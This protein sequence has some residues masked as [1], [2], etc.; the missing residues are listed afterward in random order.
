MCYWITIFFLRKRGTLTFSPRI[1]STWPWHEK[2][3]MKIWSDYSRIQPPSYCLTNL[4]M[5]RKQHE[6]HAIF[7]FV[8]KYWQILKN[9]VWQICKCHANNTR[10]IKFLYLLTNIDKY[11]LTNLFY[12]ASNTRNMQFS[13]LL[14]NIDKYCLTNLFYHA[15]NTRNMQFLA[16]L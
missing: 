16:P 4:L 10:N 3:W 14:T 6:Q 7:I 9:I 11:C 15:S 8:D 13:Y 2:A 5:P 12:H 1:N